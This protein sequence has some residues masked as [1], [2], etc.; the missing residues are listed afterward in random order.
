MKGFHNLAVKLFNNSALKYKASFNSKFPKILNKHNFSTD[1][2]EKYKLF[3]LS[4]ETISTVK[5]TVPVLQ[6]HGEALT[7]HFYNRMFSKDGD[8][9]APLFN[10][11]NQFSKQQ[12]KALANAICAYAENIDNL[13]ALID[14]VEV[15]AQ[16]HASLII[17]PEHYPIV[18]RNLIASI[19]EVLGDSATDNVIKAWTE[20]YQL[21][22]N[23]C[24][25]REDDIYDEQIS[26]I[27]G[28]NGFK[29]FN[30]SDKQEE[31]DVITSFYLK[32]EDGGKLPDFKPGQYITTR[33]P[34][35]DDSSTTMRN[36]S[37]SDISDKDYLRISVKRE[38]GDN[39]SPKGYVSNILHKNIKIG[40]SIEIAPPCGK[41]YLDTTSK[42][43]MPLILM[44]GGVGITP[45]LSM[46][47]TALKTM[48]GR[49]IAFMHA[50]RDENTQAFK[51]T[52]DN[53]DK[54]YS[55]LKVHYSYSEATPKVTMSIINNTSKG[56]ID[57][58]LIKSMVS[59]INGEYYFCGPK[60]FMSSMNNNL[61]SMKV[62]DQQINYEFFGPKSELDD[63][64]IIGSSDDVI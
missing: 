20:A 3:D 59:D 26:K 57:K 34:T 14:A 11:S 23:I 46:L 32:P 44:A 27:G 17:K 22:A 28:W 62:P 40:D 52:I 19:K 37:L 33:F 45:I 38:D 6:K 9:V 31:S 15:I 8:V 49:E 29:N 55:N 54:K 58:K 4:N 12:P 64:D 36:Y 18:G 47:F 5:A 13:G 30:V 48:P 51:D 25:N 39:I 21:L 43:D 41:F 53:L 7:E 63:I 50:N 56:F 2:K 16:K 1:V 10:S 35:A 42:G 61:R 24:I 60:P